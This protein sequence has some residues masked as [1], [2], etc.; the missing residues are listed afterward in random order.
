MPKVQI[1]DAA[2]HD[3]I[4]VNTMDLPFVPELNKPIWILRRATDE[5]REGVLLTSVIQ[6]QL[7][8]EEPDESGIVFAG[9]RI[10]G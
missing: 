7:V 3:K 2:N 9:R 6:Y 5:P 4:L 8:L 10:D 1:R